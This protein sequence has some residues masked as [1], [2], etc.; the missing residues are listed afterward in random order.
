MRRFSIVRGGI[1]ALLALASL[2]PATA[3]Q[4]TYPSDS[5]CKKEELCR[6]CD[7]PSC[8]KVAPEAAWPAD[9]LTMGGAY[10]LDAFQ[11]LL[12]ESPERIAYPSGGGLFVRYPDKRAIA[13]EWIKAEQAPFLRKAGPA[14]ELVFSDIPRIQYTKTP[15]DAEP[16]SLTDKRIWRFALLLKDSLFSKA[17][18]QFHARR[19]P[20]TM[21]V[22]EG[23]DSENHAVAHLVH[24]QV[25][26]AYLQVTGF[27]FEFD[28]VVKILATANVR[29]K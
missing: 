15:A 7:G 24:D 21:Y 23:P 22:R 12:P 1:A 16:Q 28:E 14:G 27:G 4:R 11:F 18:R 2:V 20:I 5:L 3:Q 17:Q 25:K 19:G 6:R 8:M 13:F 10:S 29:E 9:A 26:G